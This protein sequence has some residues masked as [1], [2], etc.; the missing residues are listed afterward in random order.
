MAERKVSKMSLEELELYRVQLSE[1]LAE[2]NF[3]LRKKIARGRK[4]THSDSQIVSSEEIIK[5][6]T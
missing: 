4:N 1:K 6:E 3:Y 2:V 5:E